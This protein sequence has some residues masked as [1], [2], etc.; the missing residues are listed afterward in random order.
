[1]EQCRYYWNKGI[2]EVVVLLK[3]NKKVYIKGR[4]HKKSLFC[5]VKDV[6]IITKKRSK[7]GVDQTK[8]GI[9]KRTYNGEVYD[10]LSELQFLKE[11]ILP[12]MGSGEIIKWERQIKFTL[13]E[14]FVY[15]GKKVLPITYVADYIVYWKN[16]TRTIIDVKGC[17]DSV[18]KLKRKLFQYRYPDE[19]YIW[20]CRSIKYGDGSNWLLYEDLEK[21]RKEDKKKKGSK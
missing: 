20:M 16:N 3:L 19:D 8:K 4:L 21:K 17:P 1:M 13:Q 14:G 15:K 10:S 7:Y 9:E 6:K 11:W 5:H 12:K 2:K 18:A